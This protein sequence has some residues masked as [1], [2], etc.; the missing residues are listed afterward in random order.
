MDYSGLSL[1]YLLSVFIIAFI[2]GCIVNL[3]RE[4][5]M[6]QL[7]GIAFFLGYI[8]FKLYQVF[9][10]GA[11]VSNRE[12]LLIL[13][14]SITGIFACLLSMLLGFWLFPAIRSRFRD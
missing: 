13:L 12:L 14:P 4:H 3:L 1:S 6:F 9:K 8:I 2:S 10:V 7:A 11:E 5:F